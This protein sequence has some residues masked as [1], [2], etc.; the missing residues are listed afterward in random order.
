MENIDAWK[1]AAA[2]EGL[3]L[4][5]YMEKMSAKNLEESLEEHMRALA[6][7]ATN[8]VDGEN[9]KDDEKEDGKRKMMKRKMMNRKMMALRLLKMRLVVTKVTKL[10]LGSLAK[11]IVKE[12]MKKAKRKVQKVKKAIAK[13][14]KFP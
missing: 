11:V 12:K 9:K 5:D 4:E 1:K 10:P 14:V 13:K 2:A 3:S 6:A 7:E 8:V